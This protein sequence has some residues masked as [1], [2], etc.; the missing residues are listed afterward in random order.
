MKELKRRMSSASGFTLIEL[1][2]V[3]VIIGILAGVL[4]AVIDP[5]AQQSKA[6]DANVKAT[7]N[8]VS[9]A[10]QGYISAYG[11][12]PNDSQ[13]LA[14][15]A[16]TASSPNASCAAG[17]ADYTCDFT[18]TGN[19]LPAT[20][21]AANGYTGAG[22]GQ[23][24]YRYVGTAGSGNFTLWAKSFGAGTTVFRYMNNGAAAGQIQ[25]CDT[26]TPPANCVT[27]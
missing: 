1:L 19:Q 5:Q 4:I 21:G 14:G 17:G 25:H 23:C 8:K 7:M 12:S 2:L 27:P 22:A 3:I 10:T 15:L 16:A 6:R 18:I 24:L 26:A 11:N 9:L 20:C 13:F